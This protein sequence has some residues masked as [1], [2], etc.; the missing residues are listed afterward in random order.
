MNPKKYH[1]VVCMSAAIHQVAAQSGCSVVVDVGSGLGYLGQVL[2]KSYNYKIIGLESKGCHT[3]GAE[4]R[5][6]KT[7]ST[8]GIKNVTFELHDSQESMDQ[9]ATVIQQC[10]QELRQECDEKKNQRSAASGI[11]GNGLKSSD[12][13]MEKHWDTDNTE[14][15]KVLMV[16][17]HC[18][19]DLTPIMMKYFKALDFIKGLCCVSCCFHRM[20]F[21]DDHNSNCINFPMSCVVRKLCQEL[22]W[23]PSLYG[24]RLAAQETRLGITFIFI[25]MFEIVRVL[26]VLYSCR[27]GVQSQADHEYHMKNVAYRGILQ[28]Y[29]NKDGSSPPLDKIKESL[30][31]LYSE[32]EQYFKYI[33]PI[34]ALQVTLQPLLEW[35]IYKDRELWLMEQGTN[36]T[37]KPIFDDFI[38]PRNL[39]IIAD[40]KS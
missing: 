31:E 16:G 14:T 11:S 37:V 34:T 25:R 40:K 5:L 2:H 29:L 23:H 18:C 9:F 6:H 21:L 1:E 33:E 7:D 30:R 20:K 8:M 19:G 39:A 13:L 24:L 38:S 10:C 26:L 27:W 15:E 36:A 4:K 3:T 32:Q 12:F 17:L 28:L 22:E 35:L